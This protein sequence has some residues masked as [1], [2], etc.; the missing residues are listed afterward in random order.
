[1]LGIVIK[2]QQV[3]PLGQFARHQL[4]R[5]RIDDGVGQVDTL[6]AQA[7]GQRVAQSRF[8]NESE[9][10]QQFA[11]RPVGLHLLQQGNAQ[12]IL[13]KDALGDQDLTNLPWLMRSVHGLKAEVSGEWLVVSGEWPA[14]VLLTGHLPLTTTL[15]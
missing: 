10:N 11:D 14:L 8:R 5:R 1:M 7:L 9:R 6:L 3:V 15:L 13:A 2:R 12:L 4:Q